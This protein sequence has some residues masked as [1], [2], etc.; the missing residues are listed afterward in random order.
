METIQTF[1]QLMNE[2]GWSWCYP[3]HDFKQ[4]GSLFSLDKLTI[5][6]G[7]VSYKTGKVKLSDKAYKDFENF[8]IFLKST[9]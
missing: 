8:I 2:I 1:K 7:Y 6:P 9:E 4:N 3:D 5:E